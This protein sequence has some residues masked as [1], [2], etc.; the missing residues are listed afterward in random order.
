VY[1]SPFVS[2]DSGREIVLTKSTLPPSKH[3]LLQSDAA[4]LTILNTDDRAIPA[5]V[6]DAL[7][8]TARD[9]P[10]YFRAAQAGRQFASGNHVRIGPDGVFQRE[11]RLFDLAHV[12]EVVPRDQVF[13][14]SVMAKHVRKHARRGVLIGA[15]VGAGLTGV[16]LL[17]CDGCGPGPMI[18]GAVFGAVYGVTI[19]AIAGVIAPKSPNLVYRR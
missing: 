19:G 7:V 5:A 12:V 15:G 8:G 2:L 9:H 14:V 4:G 18:L 11:S 10:D 16:G 6:R 1:N 3:V 17:A 13:E